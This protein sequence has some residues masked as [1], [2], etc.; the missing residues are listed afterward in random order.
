MIGALLLIICLFLINQTLFGLYSKR[1]NWF[2][3]KLMNSLYFYHLVFF[4]VYYVY[5]LNNP[6]D[7]WS[8]YNSPLESNN[9]WFDFFMPGT[10]FID[11]LSF[12]FV[13]YLNF[14]Y[15][16]MMVLYSWMGYLGFLFSYLF[17]RENI[18]VKVKVFKQIDLLILTLFLPNMHFWTS[19]LG[20][21]APIF[22]GLMMFA[23]SIKQPQSRILTLIIGIIFIYFIRPHVFLFVAAGTVLGF[24]S[25][26]E[27]ISFWK[28]V[29]IYTGMIGG[30]YLVQDDILGV[31][32]LDNS[33]DVIGDFQ[34]FSNKRSADLSEFADSA[35]S[36]SSYPLPIKLF[37]FWFRPLFF[38]AP[39]VLGLIVSAENLVYLLLFFKILNKRFFKFLKKAPVSVKM[40]LTVFFLTSFAMTFVMSNLGI[41]MRQKSMVMYFLFFTIYYFLA[42]EKYDKIIAI[43]RQRKQM[44]IPSTI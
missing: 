27:K 18:P 15:E 24:M 35:V 43:R 39:G 33:T 2:S 36:M 34:D 42:Q 12:P 29:L 44:K 5:A 31:A 21:G 14:N 38:D 17:F 26:K 40:S 23:Y 28:K 32:G 8:Y 22:M 19:S 3:K 41:I 25:G 1:H 20:K 4:V 30:L 13:K 37:T 7:S 16:M 11:F 9:L 6:S 10:T